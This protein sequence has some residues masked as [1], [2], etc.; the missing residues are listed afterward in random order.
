MAGCSSINKGVS[1]FLAFS[2]SSSELLLQSIFY[3]I[4]KPSFFFSV[5]SFYNSFISLSNFSYFFYETTVSLFCYGY[6]PFL[7]ETKFKRKLSSDSSG[8]KLLSALEL[9]L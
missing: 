2:E 4:Y 3:L 8:R 1:F 9:V 7:N 5:L 6:L